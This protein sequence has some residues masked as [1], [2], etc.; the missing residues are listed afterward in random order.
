MSHSF[1]PGFNQ[2]QKRLFRL[3]PRLNRPKVNPK[4]ILRPHC[5]NKKLIIG[6]QSGELFSFSYGP[7]SAR[8]SQQ[9]VG[10]LSQMHSLL[11]PVPL[12]AETAELCSGLIRF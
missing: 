1:Q 6:S 10:S 5:D 11:Q 4:E 12:T 9:F 2:G 7:V 3:I 8:I